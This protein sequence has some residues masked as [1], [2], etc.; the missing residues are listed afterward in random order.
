MSKVTPK[1]V[2]LLAHGLLKQYGLD[3]LGWRFQWSSHKRRF[4]Q[5][6]YRKKLI[7]VSEFMFRMT[8]PEQREDFLDTVKHE[9][10]HALAYIKDGHCGHGKPWK[11]WAVKLGANPRAT[12]QI[13]FKDSLEG[14]KYV[15]IDTSNNDKIVQR[16]YRKPRQS[17][18]RNIKH[19]T[20]NDRPESLGKLKIKKVI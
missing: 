15:I 16:Y 7:E 5:C 11:K 19:Y 14:V 1:R 10:A 8:V 13:K 20:A 6:D 3:E 18:F 17:V 12:S 4:G 9:V 2:R